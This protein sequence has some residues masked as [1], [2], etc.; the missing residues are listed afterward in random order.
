MD[1]LTRNR[2]DEKTILSHNLVL[3]ISLDVC[4]SPNSG[5]GV[6]FWLL[7]HSRRQLIGWHKTV[8]AFSWLAQMTTT[9][10]PSSWIFEYFSNYIYCFLPLFNYLCRSQYHLESWRII[11]CA[12]Y[13][14]KIDTFFSAAKPLLSDSL[15]FYRPAI[16]ILLSSNTTSEWNI[17]C[18]KFESFVLIAT[19]NYWISLT[20]HSLLA[21]QF[22][23]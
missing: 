18:R 5:L 16:P 20:R 14:F 7:S 8:I 17:G 2:S 9:A 1:G 11:Y 10:C 3:R 12:S 13:G 15:P 22:A 21:S 6:L 19:V 4:F 23:K